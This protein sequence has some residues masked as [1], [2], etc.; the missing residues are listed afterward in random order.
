MMNAPAFG[1]QTTMKAAC[2]MMA[3][4]RKNLAALWPN[5][6]GVPLPAMYH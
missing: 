6:S 4:R 1:E 2:Y 3:E 5:I